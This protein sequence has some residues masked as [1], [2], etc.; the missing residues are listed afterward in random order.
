MTRKSRD[1]SMNK[2]QGGRRE[3]DLLE[4]GKFVH[5]RR[6]IAKKQME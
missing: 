3:L 6:E 2:T 5:E 4:Y 1:K